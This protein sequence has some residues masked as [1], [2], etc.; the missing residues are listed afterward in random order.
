MSGRDKV[1]L[2]DFEVQTNEQVA[3]DIWRM[4]CR[5]SLAGAMRPGQFVQV[6][7][8]GDDS[9]VLRIPLSFSRAEHGVIELVYAVVGEGTR[10]M[11]AMRAGIRSTMVGPCGN[12][13]RLPD[14]EGRSLLIAGGV[15]LPPIFAC[16]RMLAGADRPF[17][18][19]VGAQTAG[20]HYTDLIE[21]LRGMAL[22]HEC[23]CARKVLVTTDDGSLGLRGYTTQAMEGLLAERRY[24]TVYACG[25]EPMMAGVARIAA[26]GHMACQVSLERMMGCGFGACSCC[27]VALADGSQALCCQEGPVFDAE[28]IAW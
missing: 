26:R 15:G 12:G 3:D 10:R 9:H 23:D 2:Y 8:P 28:V 4:R 27:N 24:A 18:V 19:V 1:A 21:E 6:A 25:P 14:S 16:A 22:G 11:S 7:V 5:T 20:K 13:W 17:D